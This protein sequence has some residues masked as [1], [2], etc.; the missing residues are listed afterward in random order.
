MH[1]ADTMAVLYEQ[2]LN[3]W[4]VIG[5][6]EGVESGSTPAWTDTFDI[7]YRFNRKDLFKVVV[8]DI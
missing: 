2:N 3:G 1:R 8:Y 6:T 7:P 4:K 5:Y